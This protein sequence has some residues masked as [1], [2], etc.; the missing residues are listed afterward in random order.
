M[1]WTIENGTINSEDIEALR[2]VVKKAHKQN[3]LML[4]S[5]SDSGGSQND[6]SF[7]C[8]WSKECTRIG[9]ASHRGDKLAWVNEKS[10]QFLLPGKRIPIKNGNGKA[11]SYEW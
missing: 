8:Q 7:P 4:C 9:G 2:T 1:S 3:I 10:V 11:H 6:R 5:T